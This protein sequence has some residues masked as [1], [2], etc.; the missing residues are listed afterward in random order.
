MRGQGERVRHR[1]QQEDTPVRSQCVEPA[2]GREHRI[3][4]GADDELV[5]PQP[6]ACAVHGLDEE[7]SLG[8]INAG[9]LSVE[10]QPD[11]GCS[12]SSAMLRCASLRQSDTS[13]ET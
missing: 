13:P 6:R 1:V 2:D 8:G 11:A 10:E 4:A 3:G 12:S 9:R 5:V 7:P